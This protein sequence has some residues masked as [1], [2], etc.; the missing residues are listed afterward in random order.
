MCATRIT[1]AF[2]RKASEKEERDPLVLTVLVDGPPSSWQSAYALLG[3]FRGSFIAEC[4]A[5]NT[6]SILR[7]IHGASLYIPGCCLDRPTIEVNG[8]ELPPDRERSNL[9][10]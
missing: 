8:K 1:Y 10:F 4:L 7:P 3:F 2:G 5:M 9:W 6:S